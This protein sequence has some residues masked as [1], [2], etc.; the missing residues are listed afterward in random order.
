MKFEGGMTPYS[1]VPIIINKIITGQGMSVQIINICRIFVVINLLLLLQGCAWEML[2]ASSVQ[3][4]LTAVEGNGLA[5]TN[6]QNRPDLNGY[7]L[8]AASPSELLA[9]YS[10][11]IVQ[12]FK[13]INEHGYSYPRDSDMIGTP[14]L[15]RSSKGKPYTK[16]DVSRPVMYGFY[17][18]RVI[19]RHHHAQL[20]YTVWYPRH[21]RT[22]KFD[23]EPGNVD[24][25]VV[26]ITLDDQNRPLL[27]ETVLACG[28][29]HKVFVERKV[30]LA[31]AAYYGPPQKGKEYSIAKN[32][33][34]GFDFE[35][36][37]IV[38]SP[39]MH[40]SAPVIFVSSGEH[41]VLGLHPSENLNWSEFG[42]NIRRY[43]L[44][45]YRELTN[46]PFQ[47]EQTVMPMFNP[48]NDQ[49]VWG[50]ERMER[51][52]F[53][54]IGTDDAGHPRRNDQILLHFDQAMWDDPNIYTKYLR[55]PPR[56]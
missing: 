18:N 23:I 31:S 4:P 55:L 37:G 45:H 6:E 13:D 3:A 53:W 11:I 49:Q 47:N 12:Q 2:D 17:D 29:Y 40:P 48:N 42:E 19:A 50:A 24:S 22:K 20:T 27:Y 34:F 14:Y 35:I 54:V 38:D 51:F 7:S 30:E 10:P 25:N 36:A 26:R 46:I 56:F 43:R 1:Q 41:K 32:I 8:P 33:P 39:D 28:C 44:A 5:Y 15:V 16:I 52:I 21:P 9:F